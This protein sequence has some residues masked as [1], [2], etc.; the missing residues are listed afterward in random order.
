MLSLGLAAGWSAAL[1]AQAPLPETRPFAFERAE[2][3]PI[4]SLRPPGDD[5]QWQPVALPDN[6]YVTRPGADGGGWYRFVLPL[7]SA[8]KRVHS[9]YFPRGSASIIRAFVNGNI[10]GSTF[11]LPE[12]RM[13]LNQQALIFSAS[14]ALFR[15][16][17]NVLHV[18]I[19]ARS[20]LRQGLTR[21]WFGDGPLIRELWLDRFQRQ[22]ILAV[23]FAFAVVAA[24][25][26]ALAVWVRAREEGAFLWF[27]LAAVLLGV[28]PIVS[29]FQNFSG[30]GIWRDVLHLAFA[31]AYAPALALG[32]MHMSGAATRLPGVALWATLVLGCSLP[33]LVG[34]AAYPW[35]TLALGVIFLAALVGAFSFLFARDTVGSVW[36]RAAAAV[37]L[38][39]AIALAGHDLALWMAWADYESYSLLP[40]TAPMITL[41]VGALLITRHLDAVRGLAESKE[42][43][44]R[45][46]VERTAEI[47]R[48][49][50]QVRA[51]EYEHA[52]DTERQ[53]IMADIH[54]G[55]GA[56]L[57][58]LLSVVQ[59]EK[60]EPKEVERRVHDALL[61]LRLAVDAQDIP[62]GDLLTA[63]AT[64]RYRMRDALDAA[65]IELDWRI[66]D[67]PRLD[68]FT[69]RRILDIQHIV[70]EA[71]TNAIRHARATR[72]TVATRASDSLVE[73][74]IA[75][76]GRG[77]DSG[78]QRS[79][80][81]G[82]MTMQ[83]RAGAV[84]GKLAVDSQPG[85]GTRVALTLDLRR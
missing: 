6:W 58:S 13:R 75:D 44:E 82:L 69:P 65:G 14:P 53:R 22:A 72:I 28:P 55:L 67:I 64:V 81:R 68:H 11:Q 16:G 23:A 84:G 49:H 56:S 85:G 29:F 7:M 8:P 25:L 10:I 15:E 36:L 17:R 12:I 30:L 33:L 21:V 19:E 51:L 43:L 76:D 73:L 52:R 41:A 34:Q 26:I 45:R 78:A 63:L 61:E 32:A 18:Y 54:D 70:L 31:H 48:T 20:D 2:F 60:A 80:G 83:R 50:Q 1:I 40:F 35:V 79:H 62:E 77:F 24:G 47:E 71:L 37:A 27:G 42:T 38:V 4:Q 39:T 5:V 9:V 59:S 46:V 57:V 66:G 74:E 3:V